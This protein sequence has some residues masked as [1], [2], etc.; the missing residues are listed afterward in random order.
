MTASPALT[1]RQWHILRTF[2]FG[3]PRGC[4]LS[5]CEA[6]VELGI[7]TGGLKVSMTPIYK[8]LEAVGAI[9]RK[10]GE[11]KTMA[12]VWFW[13]VEQAMNERKAA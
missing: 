13:R 10:S 7:T 5:E 3:G 12:C 1:D 9:R 11:K 4:G 2:C 6:A 8:K